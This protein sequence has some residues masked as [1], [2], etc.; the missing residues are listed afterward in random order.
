MA[1]GFSV[2]THRCNHT[3]ACVSSLP[4]LKLKIS[5]P[6]ATGLYKS[7]EQLREPLQQRLKTWEVSKPAAFGSLGLF[8]FWVNTAEARGGQPGSRAAQ[9]DCSQDH[10][11]QNTHNANHPPLR[12][13]L[14]S[15]LG[16]GRGFL[17]ERVV[18]PHRHCP[19]CFHKP[20]TPG[21]A[22]KTLTWKS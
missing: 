19:L 22:S 4:F 17:W 3:A 21:G 18:L 8:Y 9:T 14:S 10:V 2:K 16:H 5:L 7:Q 1:F 13:F 20:F 12:T 6:T 11:N 15:A